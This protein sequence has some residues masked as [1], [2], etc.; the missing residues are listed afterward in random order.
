MGFMAINIKE[1]MQCFKGWGRR[2]IV[3]N[4]LRVDFSNTR[5]TWPQHLLSLLLREATGVVAGLSI[6]GA[7]SYGAVKLDILKKY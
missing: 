2:R 7:M 4:Q 1:L 3:F 5:D 6:E